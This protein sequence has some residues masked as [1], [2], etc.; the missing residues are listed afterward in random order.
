LLL[1]LNKTGFNN[2]ANHNNGAHLGGQ[3]CPHFGN[4]CLLLRQPNGILL[5]LLNK[6]GF[7]M[8]LIIGPH[9]NAAHLGSQVLLQLLC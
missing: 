6:T 4:Q 7:N 9:H 1:L 2:E 5:L 3:L 8:K